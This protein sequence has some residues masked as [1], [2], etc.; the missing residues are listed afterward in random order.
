M[1]ESHVVRKMCMFFFNVFLWVIF[2]V[3]RGREFHS[4]GASCANAVLLE[5]G[6]FSV[7]VFVERSVLICSRFDRRRL[8]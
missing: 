5:S 7:I 1:S 8:K 3:S 4:T 2:R 6:I